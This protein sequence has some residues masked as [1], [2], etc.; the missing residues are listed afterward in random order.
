MDT[1][2]LQ[3]WINSSS[4]LAAIEDFMIVVAQGLG[5]LDVRLIEDDRKLCE[6]IKL[7][8]EQRDITD[9]SVRITEGFTISYL[10]VLGAYELVRAVNQRLVDNSGLFDEELKTNVNEVKL[11]FERLRIPLAKFEPSRRHRDTDDYIAYPIIH[12]EIG[13]SWQLSQT[14]YMSRSELSEKLLDLLEKIKIASDSY[15]YKE[16]KR[17]RFS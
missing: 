12:R 11:L 3:R 13:V 15:G 4:G 14:V 8:L 7:P 1:N 16:I 9:E 6:T 17:I 10:W 2:R 5:R